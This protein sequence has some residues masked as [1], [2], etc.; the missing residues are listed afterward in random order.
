MAR[1]P[2][3]DD[4][5]SG[6]VTS[7]LARVP[8]TPRWVE[9]RGM[10]L[11]GR[12]R[13]AWTSPFGD[14]FIVRSAPG[15][16]LCCFGAVAAGAVS[17]AVA[18]QDVDAV[19]CA[20]DSADAVGAEL[21]AWT[22][23]AAVLHRLVPGGRRP[24]REPAARAVMLSRSDGARLSHVPEPLRAE[25]LAAIESS[26]AAAS[27]LEGVPVAFCHPVYETETLWDVSV[28]TLEPYRRRGLAQTCFEYLCDHMAAHGKE[29][30]WGAL[31]GNAASLALARTLGFEEVDRSTVFLRPAD[32][33]RRA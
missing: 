12:C 28:D 26:H 4:L 14:A 9:T 7:L 18:G 33:R 2:R 27:F 20:P 3:A 29:P 21:P 8:D 31:A 24:A 25:I 5:P 23:V 10:L 32:R 13:V 16:L 6:D 15:A 17:S 30:V 1:V 19:L 22:R 11:S